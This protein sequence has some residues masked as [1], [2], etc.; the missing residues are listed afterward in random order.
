M[1]ADT[2][3]HELNRLL[4]DLLVKLYKRNPRELD[5][6]SGM[7]I[8]QRQNQIF[9]TPGRLVFKELKNLQG[10]AALDLAF[11]PDYQGDRVFA[12]MTGLTGMIRSTYNWKSELF[13]LDSLDEQ[14]LFNSARNIE[15]LVWRLS[16]TRDPAGELL[17]LSNSRSGEEQ[18]LSYER[19]FGKMIAIQDMMAFTVAGKWDRGVNTAV[20]TAIFFPMGM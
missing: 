10:T 3:L 12:L 18:N 8:G 4:E 9:D 13:M 14:K 1:V 5:K 16:N 7:S 20:K 17:L 19:L 15:V 2:S 6:V 11:D